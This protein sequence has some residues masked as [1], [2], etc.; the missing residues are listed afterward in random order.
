MDEVP[1]GDEILDVAIVGGGVSGVYCGWRLLDDSAAHSPLLHKMRDAHPDQRLRVGIFE[2]SNR[3]GGRLLS[4]TPPGMPHIRC[5]LGGM[6]YLSSQ[7]YIRSLVENKFQLSTYLLPVEENEN[8]AYVRGKRM[9]IADLTNADAIPYDLAWSERGRNPDNLISYAINQIIPNVTQQHGKPL[10]HTLD[11]FL[12]E[13]RH[14]RHYGF[15]NLLARSLSTEAFEFARDVGGYD[16]TSLNWNAADTIVLN[17]DFAPGVTFHALDDGYET[18]PHLIA[19]HFTEAGG[20]IHLNHWLQSFDT[21]TLP[22]GAQGVELRFRTTPPQEHGEGEETIIRARAV[23]LAMPRRSLELLQQ[24]GAVLD[25]ARN[26][27]IHKLLASVTP[28]PLFKIFVCYRSPW[29]ETVGVTQGRSVTDLPLRQCYYWGVEGRK[30]GADPN[31]QNAVVMASY[32]DTL[33]VDFWAGLQSEDPEDVYQHALRMGDEAASSEWEQHRAPAAMVAE[34]QRQLL[35]LH[36]L[37][38]APQ[39]YD[40]VFKDWG[41]DPFGGGVNFWNIHANS[42][43]LIPRIAHPQPEVPIFICGEAYSN[44]QGWVEGALQTAELVLT[45]HFH[46][47]PPQ[48]LTETPAVPQPAP[49]QPLKTVVS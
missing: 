21:V 15:W 23:I 30:P 25:E 10:E 33:N 44:G 31:N 12:F 22:D 1:P 34:V 24:T 26:R 20:A 2:G 42:R 14:I 46:L 49:D 37:E 45:K 11:T 18:V 4:V 38:F 5:E 39:P 40:A 16:T 47:P 19:Q 17:F 6:R 28:I 35:E 48:W 36:G 8:L 9:R 32:D 3:I 41:D 43:E 29:W 13:G 7:T 27:G